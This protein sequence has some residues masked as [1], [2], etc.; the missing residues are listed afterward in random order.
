MG[1]SFWPSPTSVGVRHVMRYF[2]MRPACSP[3]VVWE[4]PVR[5]RRDTQD[6]ETHQEPHRQPIHAAPPRLPAPSL[7]PP[8]V[9]VSCD[10]P[11]APRS[12]RVLRESSVCSFLAT[13]PQYPKQRGG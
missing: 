1:A 9:S 5:S 12:L 6:A 7:P 10:R 2:K 11:S 13:T 4:S 8:C 3:E